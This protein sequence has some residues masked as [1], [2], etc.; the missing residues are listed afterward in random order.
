MITIGPA[1]F[2][3][4]THLS[5]HTEHIPCTHRHHHIAKRFL[6]HVEYLAFLAN[7][8]FACCMWYIY[9]TWH[10]VINTLEF[11]KGNLK[12][13]NG[14]YVRAH[15]GFFILAQICANMSPKRQILSQF[16]ENVNI[17]ESK[18]ASINRFQH[19]SKLIKITNDLWAISEI[20]LFIQLKWGSFFMV[21]IVCDIDRHLIHKF[22]FKLCAPISCTI[23]YFGCIIGK[24]NLK[25][26]NNTDFKRNEQVC[27]Y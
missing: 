3:F 23:S 18:D 24:K 4:G 19:Q 2:L 10:F 25:A 9:Y 27:H 7:I 20:Y 17:F 8:Q 12:H 14:Y 26:N 16:W 6:L 15:V 5:W 1:F 21:K 11:S 13:S 22:H